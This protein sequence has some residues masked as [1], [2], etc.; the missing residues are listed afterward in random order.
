MKL[1]SNT[2]INKGGG[3][4]A[5]NSIMTIFSDRDSSKISSV[6]FTKNTASMGGGIYMELATE[7]NVIKTG[8]NYTRTIYN[9]CFIKNSASY[10]GAIYNADETNYK[11]CGS[12]SYYNYN[13]S[14][15][16]EYF[17]QI[18]T[19]S[20]ILAR[21]YNIKSIKFVNNTASASGQAVYGGLLDR[22]IIVPIAEILLVRQRL[23][24]DGVSYILNVSNLNSTDAISSLPVALCFCEPGGHPNCSYQPAPFHVMKGEKIQVSLVVVD[25]VNRTLPNVI[26]Y[27]SLKYAESGLGEGQMA[28][29]TT[30]NC[31]N[32]NFSIYSPKD[33]EEITIYPDGP[34]RNAS[35][36]QKTFNVTFLNCTCPVGFQPSVFEHNNCVCECDPKL[37]QYVTN[38]SSQTDSLIRE[39][40]FWIT[41]LNRT[42]LSTPNDYNYLT[43]PHCPL[44]YCLPP[45]SKVQINLTMTYG[46][47]AQCANKRSGTL[48]GVCQP[49]L[50]L[51]LGTSSCIT[52]SNQ[53]LIIFLL[54]ASLAGIS[55]VALMLILNLTVAMGTLN[56]LIFYANIIGAN[57]STFFPSTSRKLK[58][59]YV[60][61]SWLNLDIGFDVCFFKGMDTY[62]KTWIQL[63]FLTYVI[64]L[65]ILVMLVSEHSIR[66]TCKID[67]EE[68]SSGN[69]GHSYLALLC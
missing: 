34:C 36:S 2:A 15:G 42:K 49:G 59:L 23:A 27:S 50:S 9:L 61:I 20:E 24:I 29:I 22:C 64:L 62:W 26:V 14:I 33:F 67:I 6:N 18:K 54:G 31:T 48:C 39:G 63:A 58:T 38:C 25:Q 53:Y 1:L 30:H 21:I 57:S 56:G 13:T 17:I 47:D 40:N 45:D 7:L 51:S 19:I 68:E 35:R 43:Y 66:F 3:I 8:E 32:L 46:A 5:I 69:S 12:K 65:V 10:G 52:C 28:Q 4:F 37:R 55:L 44:D 11:I 16:S 60:F 41:Y